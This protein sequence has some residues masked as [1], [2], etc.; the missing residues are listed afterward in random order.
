MK[1]YVLLSIIPLV[2]TTIFILLNLFAF[3]LID[4]VRSKRWDFREVLIVLLK[5]FCEV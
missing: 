1:F 2:L 5:L 3:S 4:A